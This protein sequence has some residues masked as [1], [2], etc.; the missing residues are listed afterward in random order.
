M[1]YYYPEYESNSGIDHSRIVD[2]LQ[3]FDI[4]RKI[5]VCLSWEQRL[6]LKVAASWDLDCALEHGF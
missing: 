1:K 2:L 5:D 6:D 3:V 4:C